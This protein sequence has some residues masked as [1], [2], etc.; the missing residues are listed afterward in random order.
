MTAGASRLDGV[1]LALALAV[2]A[3]LGLWMSRSMMV[4]SEEFI[5]VPS[6]PGRVTAR[7]PGPDGRLRFEAA[8][9]PGDRRVLLS[10]ERP[11]LAL[12]LGA[13]RYP[14]MAAPH[15]TGLFLWPLELLRPLHGDDPFAL[16]AILLSLGAL[17]IALTH[18][19]IARLRGRRLASLAAV[20]MAVSSCFVCLT[21]ILQNFETLPWLWLVAALLCVTDVPA[22]APGAGDAR[23]EVPTRRLVMAAGCV[24]LALLANVKAV[25]LLGPL[26]LLAWR[27]GVRFDRVRAP[28]WG[29]MMAAGAAP[30]APVLAPFAM[31]PSMRWSQ[32]RGSNLRGDLAANLQRPEKLLDAAHDLI[33]EWAS[34]GRYMTRGEVDAPSLALASAVCAFVLVDTARTLARR[35]GCAVTAACGVTIVTYLAVVTLLYAEFPA[36]YTPLHAVYGVAI[37]CAVERLVT[38]LRGIV[39]TAARVALAAA[40]FAAFAGGTVRSLGALSEV[41]FV[42]NTRVER[43]LTAY[44]VAHPE[45]RSATVTV[46]L[47][48]GGVLDA[49][50]RGRL[51]TVQ[52][53]PWLNDCERIDRQTE[54][55]ACLNARWTSLLQG[56]AGD[57]VIRVVLPASLAF[58][59]RPPELLAAQRAQL[60]AAARA[61]GMAV[62]LERTFYTPANVPAAL[63]FRVT[64]AR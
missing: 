34:F 42:T 10:G 7:S 21:S 37:G 13:R 48:A 44:L 6:T 55:A 56:L 64:G 53:H 20:G 51:R 8:C 25:F 22:L 32:G 50:S 43:E 26:A 61:L 3:A 36:N 59:S 57:G 62:R 52:A 27:L 38:H 29:A 11:T 30:L 17:S 9:R 23:G 40:V 28:Q 35:R 54:L 1:L 60:D 15:F 39:P 58:V 16:R 4:F 14:I 5:T 24:G 45:P 46:N 31:D 47:L 41:V 18:R 49:I 63:L 33:H 2:F 12:C 19:V